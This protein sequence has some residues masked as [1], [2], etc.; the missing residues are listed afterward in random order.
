MRACSSATLL[1]AS[2]LLLTTPVGYALFCELF[3]KGNM[4]CDIG[5][6]RVVQI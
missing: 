5:L 1:F 4:C 2:V 3:G 6:G